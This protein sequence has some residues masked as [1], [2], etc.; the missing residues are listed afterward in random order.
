MLQMAKGKDPPP[1]PKPAQKPVKNTVPQPSDDSKLKSYP[2]QPPSRPTTPAVH[3]T[4]PV[5]KHT[6][7]PATRPSNV[8]SLSKS[9]PKPSV[10]QSTSST[11]PSART[12]AASKVRHDT[13]SQNA[14]SPAGRVSKRISFKDAMKKANSID[15][16]KLEISLKTVDTRKQ[17]AASN[18][19]RERLTKEI[20]DKPTN[21]GAQRIQNPNSITRDPPLGGNTGKVT[22]GA[23]V[24]SS[25]PRAAPFA[26]P[27]AALMA[28]YQAKKAKQEHEKRKRQGGSYEDNEEL[29]DFV[30]SEE[31]EEDGGVDAS[32]EIWSLYNRHPRP[33]YYDSESDDDMEAT[34]ADILQEEKRSAFQARRE[35]EEEER[36]LEELARKKANRLR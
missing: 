19:S 12:A 14:P 28:K 26:Q 10:K 4:A 7:I 13:P 32:S 9:N 18:R 6:P 24:P 1:A 5:R 35:D 22:S 31:E 30:V 25:T 23:R 21:T 20:E 17:Q 36:R 11:R 29:D 34:G 16:S 15:K 33:Q 2:Q 8:A 3:S 27:N